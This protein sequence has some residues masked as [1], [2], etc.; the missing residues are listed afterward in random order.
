MLNSCVQ[1]EINH[2]R[3]IYSLSN[4]MC[5]LLPSHPPSLFLSLLNWW[6]IR[7]SVTSRQVRSAS[8][9]W[10]WLFDLKLDLIVHWV[11]A[12]LLVLGRWWLPRR[13]LHLHSAWQKQLFLL[14]VYAIR[15]RLA[16]ATGHYHIALKGGLGG[17]H[18][19]IIRLMVSNAGH[20]YGCPFGLLMIVLVELVNV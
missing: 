4:A 1:L 16:L 7:L 9:L 14:R 11:R 8:L 17:A 20:G 3:F 15:A 6:C 13:H 5:L 12:V 10:L 2:I 19:T 18:S